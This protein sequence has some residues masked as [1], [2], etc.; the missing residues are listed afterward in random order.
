M[1]FRFVFNNKIFTLTAGELRSARLF[2]VEMVKTRLA[3]NYF[4]VFRDP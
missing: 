3:G 1:T 4:S 2:R